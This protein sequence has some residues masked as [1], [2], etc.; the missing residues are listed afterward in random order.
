MD[1]E[2]KIEVA[3]HTTAGRYPAS[4]DDSTPVHQKIRVMLEKAAKALNITNIDEWIARVDGK[5]VDPNTTYLGNG[6]HGNVV[7]DFGPRESGG[8]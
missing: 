5:E 1:H 8:G 6:L 2:K 4:G 7:I 3:V